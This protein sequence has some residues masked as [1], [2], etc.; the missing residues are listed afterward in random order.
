MKPILILSLSIIFTSCSGILPQRSFSDEM[1]FN[2]DPLF[3]PGE[4]FP[5]VGGDSGD[6]YRSREDIRKRTPMFDK[7]FVQDKEKDFLKNELAQKEKEMTLEELTLYEDV[8]PYLQN[9][10]E[11][12]YFANLSM[13]EKLEYARSRRINVGPS[14]SAP[15]MDPYGTSALEGGRAIASVD[16]RLDR[17]ELY[18]GMTKYEVSST[19][20]RPSEVEVAGNPMNQNER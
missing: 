2:G 4:D 16:S 15:T 10:S 5:V 17:N 12:I 20:G 3:V 9:T 8:K 19:W 11:R 6:M 18:L 14:N 1:E 13:G 7:D